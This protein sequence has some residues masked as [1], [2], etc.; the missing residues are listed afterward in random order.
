M[1]TRSSSPESEPP[2]SQPSGGATAPVSTGVTD[3]DAW[4][5][6]TLTPGIG[7]VGALR[8]LQAFGGPED[9]LRAPFT[10]V[11][12]CVGPRI[13]ACLLEPPERVALEVERALDWA[14]GSGRH[15]VTLA[16]PD[17]P[18]RLL[19]IGDPPALLYVVGDRSLLERPA[20]AVVGSRHATRGGLDNAL[21]FAEA[22]AQRGL[23][24]VS[25]L[26]LGIDGA[27]HEGALRAAAGTLAV[28]G[29]GADR[30]Y[31]A[32]HRDLAA[33]IAEAGALV[34]EMPLG[35]RPLQGHFPRRNRLIAGLSLG[36]LVV[37]AAPHSGSLITARLAADFGREVFAIPGSIHSPVARGCHALIRQ[38]AKLVESAQHVLEELDASL[39]PFQA[40]PVAAAAGAKGPES[41]DAC[42]VLQALGWEPASLESLQP[43][44]G[45]SHGW[46]AQR[47]LE[48]ELLGW[49]E[50]LPDGRVQQ[51]AQAP[52]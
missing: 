29:T 26:A 38:G 41:P 11:S 2:A 16:D 35:T 7:P 32:R 34:T 47:V 27:A 20:V 17:Y 13:A 30:I 50:R 23:C 33:R 3:L 8:L 51:R 1:E 36:V 22:L 14:A 39:G 21:A 6:I 28:M 46:L 24:V 31:P 42:R 45:E 18:S 12:G 49:L 4:L 43:M 37:E 5:R 10:A 40:P 19:E 48:L 25:G 15:L 44:L 9:V 52:R